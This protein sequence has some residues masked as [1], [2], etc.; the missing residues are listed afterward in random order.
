M[1]VSKASLIVLV[2][3]LLNSISPRTA[4]AADPE[5]SKANA[6]KLPRITIPKLKGT[7]NINGNLDEPVWSKAAV[8]GPFHLNDGSAQERERTELR[9]WYDDDALYLG[10]RCE[11]TD[12]QATFTNHDSKFWEEEVAEFFITPKDLGTYF[13]LQWNPLGA[14]FDAVIKNDLGPDGLSKSF[15]GDWTYTAHGMKSAVQLKGT[16]NNSEDKDDFWQVEVRVPFKD[17]GQPTPKPHETWRGNF[18]RF[19]RSKGMKVEGVSWSPTLLPGFHEPSRFG[20]LEFG[21]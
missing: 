17:L 3:C 15:N 5:P 14:T 6:P 20:Y 1:K 13:E 8:L 19:N 10:W 21:E 7:L 12:I 2:L 4:L 16:P 18:F 11:D 9:L